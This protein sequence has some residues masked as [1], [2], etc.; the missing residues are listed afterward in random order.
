VL[1]LPV[2]RCDYRFASFARIMIRSYANFQTEGRQALHSKGRV[3]A[4]SAMH[5]GSGIPRT[6]FNLS[7]KE[8]RVPLCSAQH[9]STFVFWV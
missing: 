1:E 8:I 2:Y 4:S 3:F 6:L 9:Q 5:P 7:L